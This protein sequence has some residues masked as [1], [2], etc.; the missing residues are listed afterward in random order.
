MCFT[1]SKALCIDFARAG[2]GIDYYSYFE[3]SW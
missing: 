3:K 1:E 2:G